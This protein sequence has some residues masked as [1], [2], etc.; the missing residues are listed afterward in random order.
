METFI[1]GFVVDVSFVVKAVDQASSVLRGIADA[2]NFKSLPGLAN[3]SGKALSA[4]GDSAIKAGGAISSFG[5]AATRNITAPLSLGLGLATKTAIDFEHQMA[6]LARVS[7]TTVGTEQYKALNKE[8]LEMSREIPIA[9]E[10]LAVMATASAKLGVPRDAVG[11]FTKLTAKM[12]AS[13]DI[14]ASEAGDTAGQIAANFGLINKATGQVDFERF[15]AFGDTVNTLGDNMSTS[16]A[17]ILTAVKRMAGAQQF[18]FDERELAGV[19]AA[20]TSVGIAPEVAARGFNKFIAT[21]A[22]AVDMPD[23]VAQGFEQ[24]GMS[25]EDVEK[26]MALGQGKDVFLDMMRAANGSGLADSVEEVNKLIAQGMSEEEAFE[27]MA[28][29]GSKGFKGLYNVLG[30]FNDE[31]ARVNL[32]QLDEAMRLSGAVE[33]DAGFS[34][35]QRSFDIMSGTTKSQVQFFKNAMAEMGIAISA[36]LF[37]SLNSLA[38]SLLPVMHQFAEFATANPEIVKTG[39][40]VAGVAMAIGPVASVVGNVV[41]AFGMTAKAGGWMLQTLSKSPQAFAAVSSGAKSVGTAVGAIPKATGK[42]VGAVGKMG[43][44]MAA[45]FMALPAVGGKAIAGMFTGL[46]GLSFAG[47][48]SAFAGLSSAIAGG[49][50]AFAGLVAAA[51]PAIAVVAAVA[52]AAFALYKFWNPLTD[53]VKGFGQ[54]LKQGLQ[55]ALTALSPAFNAVKSA[56]API[57]SAFGKVWSGIKSAIPGLPQLSAGFK[58]LFKQVEGGQRFVDFGAKLGRGL[59][60]GISAVVNAVLHPIQTIKSAFSGLGNIFSGLGQTLAGGLQSAL[61]GI[62]SAFSGLGQIILTGLRGALTGLGS[63][64]SGL[65]QIILTGIQSGLT[66]IGSAFS[67]L[68]NIILSGLRGALTGIGSAFSGLGQQIISGIQSALS[69]VGSAFSG[70]GNL[71]KSGIGNALSGIS[72]QWSKLS[73]GASQ[74]VANVRQTFGNAWD[75]LTTGLQSAISKASGLLSGL[76]EKVSG[77]VNS[78]KSA[79]SGIKLPSLGGM[80]SMPGMPS[81][82]MPS[83][84]MPDF[85]GM[86]NGIRTAFSQ[87]PQIVSQSINT[88]R[89]AFAQIPAMASQLF[90]S[91]Q[92]IGVQI[93]TMF[94]GLATTIS[95][96]FTGI[97]ASVSAQAAS[98]GLA[99]ITPFQQIGMQI[100]TVFSGLTATISASFMAIVASVSAMGMQL[101]LAIITPFQQIGMQVSVIFMTISTTI[102]TA[103]MSIVATAT[104]MGMQLLMAITVPF[105]QMGMVIQTT[106]V[107]LSA[108]ISASLMGIMASITAMGASMTASISATFMGMTA[109]ISAAMAGIGA[110]VSGMM[111]SLVASISSAGAAMSAAMSSA[112]AS[113][114]AAMSSAISAIAAQVGQLPGIIQGAAGQMVSVIQGI[115]GQMFAAG[116]AI[117]SQLAAGISAGVGAAVSA[118]AGA[119]AQIRALLPGSDAERGPL[120]NISAAGPGLMKTFAGGLQSASRIPVKP[121]RDMVGAV[122]RQMVARRFENER[123]STPD[124]IQDEKNPNATQRPQQQSF[125]S[126]VMNDLLPG[127]PSIPFITP[128]APE[129]GTPVE[130]QQRSTPTPPI[131]DAPV[132]GTGIRVPAENPLVQQQ[133]TPSPVVE[134]IA[135]NTS[136]QTVEINYSPTVTI[137]SQESLDL[138]IQAILREHADDIVAMV[139]NASRMDARLSFAD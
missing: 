128:T 63:A 103:F 124:D 80:P 61:S 74:A 106:F 13:F 70:L 10:E 65:G 21:A 75:G 102:S 68:G 22:N 120:S 25:A 99:I 92:Q 116:Q 55:P 73:Q 32:D 76:R 24:L 44:G 64:F 69:G 109:S 81:I 1:R 27:E 53:V 11:D 33:G 29:R 42:A 87:I 48:G 71:I 43:K 15:E 112:F 123:V 3:Q 131:F 66:G 56:L 62:G 119:A 37:P 135:N 114:S 31:F 83:I 126:G 113:M 108:T 50:S 95:T 18:G 7:G 117:M 19:A 79:L 82:S 46:K 17:K 12:A 139:K 122:N 47:V 78:I 4:I 118:V 96:A 6:S 52:A 30:M 127:I 54:G 89:T 9:A 137:N 39:L 133:S 104:A 72:N 101:G 129:T 40:A 2:A 97:F 45:A 100:T 121:V 58:N 136:H 23:R 14:T 85:S 20:F 59:G 125:L 105:Q 41:S 35:M 8:I 57:G 138:D 86:L 84:S 34:S 51:A 93:T 49:A 16:E 36:A 132:G 60:T 130:S 88:I 111:S 115:A 77:I 110:Q 107:T 91:F 90:A 38:D 26:R 5:G 94:S 28:V 134:Q 67:G 98:L